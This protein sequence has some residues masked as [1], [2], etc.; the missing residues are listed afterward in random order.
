MYVETERF[1]SFQITTHTQMDRKQSSELGVLGNI[2]LLN[3]FIHKE[4]TYTLKTG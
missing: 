2:L 4:N 1:Y 3:G